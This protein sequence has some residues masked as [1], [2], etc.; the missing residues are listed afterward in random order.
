MAN[1]SVDDA[2]EDVDLDLYV[3]IVY[4]T[5]GGVPKVNGIICDG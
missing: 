1:G 2:Y 3:L 4:I 5:G